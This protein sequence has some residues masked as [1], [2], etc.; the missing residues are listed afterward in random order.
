[1]LNHIR[2]RFSLLVAATLI[3]FGVA[4][5][6]TAS[7][8]E[9][10]IKVVVVDLEKVVALSAAGKDLQA[11]LAKFKEAAQTE[12]SAKAEAVRGLRQKLTDGV[13]SLSEE[14]LA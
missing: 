5:A 8:Q 9:R 1:M 7:A 12:G 14:K 11:R 6:G 13:N 10:P 3:L 2:V 4:V